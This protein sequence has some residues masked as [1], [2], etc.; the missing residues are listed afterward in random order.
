MRGRNHKPAEFAPDVS[1]ASKEVITHG[2]RTVGE[3]ITL[4]TKV[5]TKVTWCHMTDPEGNIIELQSWS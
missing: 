5:G 3:I 1:A 2:G 4:T